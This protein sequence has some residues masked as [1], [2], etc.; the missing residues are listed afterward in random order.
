[1]DVIQLNI[2][3]LPGDGP[4]GTQLTTPGAGM[5]FDFHKVINNDNLAWPSTSA[6]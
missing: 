4:D 1:M 6:R 3:N 5:T 2:D